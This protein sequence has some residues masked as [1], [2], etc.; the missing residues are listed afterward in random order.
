MQSIRQE[1]A[2][3]ATWRAEQLAWLERKERQFH[4]RMLVVQPMERVFEVV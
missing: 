4:R 1:D 3:V 2:R